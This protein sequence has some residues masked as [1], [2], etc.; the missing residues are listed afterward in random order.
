MRERIHSDGFYPMAT[1]CTDYNFHEIEPH[2][3]SFWEQ[4]RAF[5]ADN[6]SERPKY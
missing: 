2:W 3:Q 5:R 6:R 4:N 1:K